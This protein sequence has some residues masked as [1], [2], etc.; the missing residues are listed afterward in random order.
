MK[1]L[2]LSPRLEAELAF[3]VNTL[4][5]L[6]SICDRCNTPLNRYA[7]NCTGD[8]SECCP[9][10]LAIENAKAEFNKKYDAPPPPSASRRGAR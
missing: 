4:G 9:G 10:F 6:P 3:V 1:G 7:D 5:D 2:K 8:L